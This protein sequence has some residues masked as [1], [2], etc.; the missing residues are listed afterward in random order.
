MKFKVI[1][2]SSRYTYDTDKGEDVREFTV[3]LRPEE[4]EDAQEIELTFH[5]FSDFDRFKLDQIFEME[6]R[7]V[8]G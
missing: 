6:L 3:D 7:P 8:E 4:N 1:A 2:T 5:N